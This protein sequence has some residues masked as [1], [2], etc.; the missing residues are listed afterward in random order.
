VSR[1]GPTDEAIAEAILAL[2]KARGPGRTICPSEAA[3]ALAGE[4]GR[5]RELMPAIRRVAGTLAER[6]ALR[7]TQRGEAVDLGVARGPVRL[8]R[9]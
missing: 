4:G 7:V 3:R 5:W 1:A 2:T 8:G 9:P 6:G